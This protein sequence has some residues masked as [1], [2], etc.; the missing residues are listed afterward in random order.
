MIVQLLKDVAV[1]QSQLDQLVHTEQIKKL[2]AR[3][4]R[5]LDTQEWEAWQALFVPNAEL[6]LAGVTRTPSELRKVTETLLAG[7]ATV[8][9]GFMPEIE[10]RGPDR[11]TAVWAM[12]DYI[13]LPAE[14]GAAPRGFRGYGHYYE[15]YS[16]IDGVWLI[17]ALTLTRLHMEPL[18]GGFPIV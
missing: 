2:K 17:A 3:Y 16:R 1:P 10:I 9:R 13:T 4:F 7:A 11:A 18:E 6:D 8:H 14:R 5:H 12:E 15:T